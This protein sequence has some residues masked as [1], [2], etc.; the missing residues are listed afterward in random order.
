M[1]E[2]G[3][4]TKG[5]NDRVQGWKLG[6]YCLLGKSRSMRIMHGNGPAQKMQGRALAAVLVLVWRPL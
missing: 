1:S 6:T 3:G 4:K 5:Y 2:V